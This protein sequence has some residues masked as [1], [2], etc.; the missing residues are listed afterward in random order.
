MVSRH[1]QVLEKPLPDNR[2][3]QRLGHTM[4]CV[5]MCNACGIGL[6]AVMLHNNHIYEKIGLTISLIAQAVT[7]YIRPNYATQ[8]P[9][10]MREH[11]LVKI[12]RLH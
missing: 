6:E 4:P 7:Q 8:R 5:T 2:D 1:L 12:V 9:Y 3:R 11:Q 10:P